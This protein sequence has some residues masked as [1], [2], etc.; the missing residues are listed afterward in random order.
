MTLRQLEY[1]VATVDAGSMTRAALELHVAQPSLST[2][3]QAL[4]AELGGRLLERSVRGVRPTAAGE[5][6]LPAAR[7]A[8]A[9]AGRARRAARAA[10]GL[11]AGEVELATVGSVALGLLPAVVRRWQ[12]E[13]PE[14][15]VRLSEVRDGPALVQAIAD[16]AAEIGIG[17][18][19]LD[20]PG[21]VLSLGWEE[22]VLVLPPGSRELRR[23]A[24]IR[25]ERLAGRRWVL[26]ERG[27]ALAAMAEALCRAEG[28]EPQP[29]VRTAQIA[30]APV[31]AA[32]GLGPALVPRNIVSAEHAA[33]VRPLSPPRARELCAFARDEFSPLAAAFLDVLARDPWPPR[34]RGAEEVGAV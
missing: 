14:R 11:Q 31:L 3:L 2:Q 33:L 29:A 27:H 9:A 1:L 32:S 8:L 18:R 25:L 15:T 4:E 6:M 24:A 7:A 10:L 12:A 20:W 16:G 26:F 17:P 13:Q 5:A 23:D 21:E 22:I 34:P 30:A 28:F 19:P